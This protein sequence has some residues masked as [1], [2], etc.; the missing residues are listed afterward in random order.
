MEAGSPPRPWREG[1]GM[2]EER[3]LAELQDRLEIEDLLT[4][5]CAAIDTGDYDLLD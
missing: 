4:R 5:Y 2:A 3:W 1:R